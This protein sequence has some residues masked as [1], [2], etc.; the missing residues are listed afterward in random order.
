MLT[1]TLVL[2]SVFEDPAW[3]AVI[4]A[5]VAL[6]IGVA[7]PFV[8]A[9]WQTGRKALG[10]G[11]TGASLVRDTARG[12]LRVL[13]ADREVSSVGLITVTLVNIGSQPIR[14]EDFDR[15]LRIRYG[16]YA[17]VLDVDVVST[18]PASLSPE[19]SVAI[20][21]DCEPGSPPRSVELAPLLLNSRDS[22][23]I[24]AV[25]D[26][27]DGSADSVTVDGRI[28]GIAE[29]QRIDDDRMRAGALIA[30]ATGEAATLTLGVI[31]GA[32]LAVNLAELLGRRPKR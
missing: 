19:V 26:C 25:V 24:E 29:L 14:R 12:R 13:F 6:P 10:Y 7:V 2:A 8:V 9:R 30:V 21:S 32:R 5:V 1:V 31:P 20:A 17:E 3:V 22:I 11:V 18:E 4:V 15:P 27:H 23:S 16:D 28:A